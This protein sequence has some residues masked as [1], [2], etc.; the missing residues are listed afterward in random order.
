MTNREIRRRAWELCR[1]N[2]WTILG[3][4]FLVSLISTLMMNIVYLLGNSILSA[5]VSLGLAVLS[6]LV[7]LGMV[8]F[9]LD[10]WHGRSAS[11]SVLFS[12]RHRFWTHLGSSILIGLIVAGVYLAVFIPV[13]IFLFIS[14]TLAA[15]LAV[16]A[17]I[18]EL[19]LIIWIA[20]RYEM[21]T[22]CVVLRPELRAT[23]CM[24]TAW[25]ASKGKI[26]RLFCNAFVLNLP[27]FIAQGLLIG[28]Q[29]FLVM[30]GQAL[31]GFGSLLLSLASTLISALLTGYIALGTY[32]LHEQLL[33]E[34]MPLPAE[35]PADEAVSEL[36][37]GDL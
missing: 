28:Y 24:R 18:A 14:E 25:H 15:I 6:A 12:Q 4:T 23:E 8:R 33:D 2:F 29:T 32:A 36:P 22:T 19:V 11:I 17:L 1:E 3:A 10:I 13:I 34:Y 16:V 30:N 21:T 7:T 37:S 9:V 27:M 26:G 20:L 31:N 35:E 5:V